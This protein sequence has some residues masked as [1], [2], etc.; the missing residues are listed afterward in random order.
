MQAMKDN[1]LVMF[2]HCDKIPDIN[3]LREEGFILAPGFSPSWQ[4]GCGITEQL[5]KQKAH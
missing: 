4:R 5:T 3:N 2:H 1:M